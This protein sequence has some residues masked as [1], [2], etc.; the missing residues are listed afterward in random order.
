MQNGMFL[1]WVSP[2]ADLVMK[3]PAQVTFLG[4]FRKTLIEKWGRWDRK[5][6]KLRK[7]VL[8]N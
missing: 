7:S 4:G 8:G 3:I 2:D 5:G 6:R 1:G